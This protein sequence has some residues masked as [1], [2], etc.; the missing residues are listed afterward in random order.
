MGTARLVDVHYSSPKYAHR[1]IGWSTWLRHVAL[2]CQQP[3]T[4]W[5]E[6]TIDTGICHITCY[7]V[8]SVPCRQFITIHRRTIIVLCCQFG[9]LT[10]IVQI[11]QKIC[12]FFQHYF[13]VTRSSITLVVNIIVCN[14]CISQW[15]TTEQNSQSQHQRWSCKNDS[16]QFNNISFSLSSPNSQFWNGVKQIANCVALHF[17][18]K[19]R[20]YF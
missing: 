13:V 18:Q 15:G 4:D 9:V 19:P 11:V 10:S 17:P 16:C 20:Y 8:L 2:I 7:C 5:V 3:L 14:R 1:K 6:H 12:C